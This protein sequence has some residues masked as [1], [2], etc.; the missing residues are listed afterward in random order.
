[1][2][3]RLIQ[4]LGSTFLNVHLTWLPHWIDLYVL[5]YKLLRLFIC[6]RQMARKGSEAWDCAC[7]HAL[8]QIDCLVDRSN[9][10]ET[11]A[12]GFVWCSAIPDYFLFDLYVDSVYGPDC[13]S[14]LLCFNFCTPPLNFILIDFSAYFK[15][16]YLASSLFKLIGPYLLCLNSVMMILAFI[17]IF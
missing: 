15:S 2:F 1:V 6:D 14:H 10:S 4:E 5:L 13:Y 17:F 3:I 7:P 16:T 8:D 12:Y 11:V 9:G